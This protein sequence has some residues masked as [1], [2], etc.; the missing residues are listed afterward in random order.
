MGILYSATTGWFYDEA[1]AAI[2]EDAVPVSAAEHRA[3]LDA[4]GAGQVI[5]PDEDGRPQ[6]TPHVPSASGVRVQ[7]D[8]LLAA[9][10]WT[11]LPDAVLDAETRSAWAAYR[12]SLRDVPQQPGFP[13]AVDWPTAPGS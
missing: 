6:A 10:D 2:P 12:Q 9:C 4:Q 3:L 11:Q 8:V 13:A 7:R 5:R 1:D